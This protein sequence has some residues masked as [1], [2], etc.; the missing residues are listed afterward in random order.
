MRFGAII[1]ICLIYLAVTGTAQEKFYASP[2]KIPLVLS[3]NF[4]ELRSNHFHA[5]ID[6]KTLARTGLD[7]AAAADGYISRISV[8]PSGFGNALYVD[9]PNGTTTVYGHLLDFR[10]DIKAYIRD[11][12][13]QNNSFSIDTQLPENKF[14]VAKGDVI[15]KSG[16]SGSSGGPHLHFEIRDRRTQVPENPLKYGFLITDKVPPKIFSLLVCPL[17]ASSQVNSSS[18]KKAFQVVQV[19][20]RYRIS[21]NQ[22]IA[23]SGEI[24]LEIDAG[25]YLDGASNRCGIYSLELKVD[26]TTIFSFE[27]DKFSFAV[28][29]FIN[30][31]IDYEYYMQTRRRYIRAWMQPGNF[32]T[33]YTVKKNRGIIEMEDGKTI[34]AELIVKDVAGNSSVLEVKLTGKQGNVP[35]AEQEYTQLFKYNRENNFSTDD[36]SITCPVGAFYDDVQFRYT[37]EST[38][39]P[40]LSPVHRL[41]SPLVPIQNPLTLKIRASEIPENLRDKA[42]IAGIDEGAGRT[43]YAGGKYKDGWVETTIKNF[44]LYAVGLDTIP[45]YIVPLSISNNAITETSRI[46]FRIVD[47]FSGI[48]DF[49]GKIDG[50]WALF[51]YDAKSDIIV[52]YFDP[53]RFELKKRHS[54]E[55]TVTDNTGNQAVYETTFW[56]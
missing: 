17:N 25:D 16:N 28:S 32:L 35:V 33:V 11:L 36:I 1:F 15:A 37:S 38:A 27:M 7:I 39:A 22:A 24:G 14:N 26:G 42:L 21:N 50:K 9:H 43:F 55:L 47:N 20:G 49:T 53:E 44:G 3:G 52:H 31:H 29:R 56:K 4:G 2:L 48:R 45:P 13:Y 6:I 23:C 40:F 41:H 30:S 51:E 10:T 54:F 34:L 5:G 8:S 18:K 12:Q 46:R 19:N